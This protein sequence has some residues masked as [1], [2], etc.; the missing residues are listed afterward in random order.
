VFRLVK[1]FAESLLT[2]FCSAGLVLDGTLSNRTEW[3]IPRHSALSY[4]AF[5]APKRCRRSEVA[6]LWNEAVNNSALDDVDVGLPIANNRAVISGLP[7]QALRCASSAWSR[8][9]GIDMD[10]FDFFAATL[11]C[12]ASV[13]LYSIALG[14]REIIVTSA[15]GIPYL[16]LNSHPERRILTSCFRK[17]CRNG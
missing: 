14:G 4:H 16:E 5:Y 13:T 2:R 15:Y 9:S 3:A 10:V 7:G 11:H 6:S 8:Q 1:Q 12:I 17:E